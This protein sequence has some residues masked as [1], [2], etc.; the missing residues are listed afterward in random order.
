MGVSCFSFRGILS[1]STDH[2]RKR[3]MQAR[4]WAV[5]RS[6]Y[7]CAGLISTSDEPVWLQE[8][9]WGGMLFVTQR[10]DGIQ[11]GCPIGRVET[12]K[13]TYRQ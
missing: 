5:G 13:Q 11:S 10:F 2:W 8:W 6:S 12:E 1:H 3:R 7:D 9:R 4:V